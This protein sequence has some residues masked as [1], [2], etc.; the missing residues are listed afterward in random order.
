MTDL[1]D[2]YD[3]TI[4]AQYLG[5]DP[6]IATAV[7]SITPSEDA[8]MQDVDIV[9]GH[10]FNPEL[11]RHGFDQHFTWGTAE[12]GPGSTSPITT[13]DDELLND[14]QVDGHALVDLT[15]IMAAFTHYWTSVGFLAVIF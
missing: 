4:D 5:Q 2:D 7:A 12:A 8:E 10:G 11:M 6:E 1:L 14:P 13:R 15:R 3:D 9:L